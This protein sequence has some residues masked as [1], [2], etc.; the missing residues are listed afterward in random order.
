M[1]PG[2]CGQCRHVRITGNRRGSVFYL[3]RRAE[4]DPRF[5]RYPPIPVFRCMG[6]EPAEAPGEAPEPDDP[7]PSQEDR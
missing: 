7:E 5:P 2:L 3:C 6:F 4:T 1:N